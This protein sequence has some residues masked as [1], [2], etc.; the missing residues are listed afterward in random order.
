MF[1]N[2]RNE[3][4]G[5]RLITV[6]I[7]TAGDCMLYL[8]LVML[9]EKHSTCVLQLVLSSHKYRIKKAQLRF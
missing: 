4:K 6:T 5:E 3:F 9:A 7:C 2:R 1:L 8:V